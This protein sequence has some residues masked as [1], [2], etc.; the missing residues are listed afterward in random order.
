MANGRR[1]SGGAVFNDFEGKLLFEEDN[2]SGMPIEHPGY[3]RT[4]RALVVKYPVNGAV[5]GDRNGVRA[6][7]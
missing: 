7:T 6:D 2:A 5:F 4:I 1:P 3:V